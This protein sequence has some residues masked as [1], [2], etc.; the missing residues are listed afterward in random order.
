MKK[1]LSYIALFLICFSLPANASYLSDTL[2]VPKFTGKIY[3][4][5]AAQSDDTKSGRT[6]TAAKKTIGGAES[7]AVA[8]DAITIKAGTYAEDV[9][10]TK[11]A[12]EL[13]GEIGVII[14]GTLYL[15]GDSPRVRGIIITAPANAQ[16]ISLS[17]SYGKIEDT[18]VIGTATTAFN[19]GGSYNMLSHTMAKGYTGTGFNVTGGWNHIM[20]AEANGAGAATRG[21]YLSNTAADGTIV[22]DS[23]SIGNATSSFHI[24]TGV[25]YAQIKN[26]VSGA[27]DGREIDADHVNTWPNFK[28]DSYVYTTTT[29]AGSEVAYTMLTITGGVRL[30]NI[31]GYVE[32]VIP[33]VACT[34]YLQLYSSG[35]TV[36][37]SVAPGVDI[38]AA[39]VGSLIGRTGP[40]TAAMT[41]ANPNTTPAKSENTSFNKPGTEV[42]VVADD[43]NPTYLRLILSAAQASGAIHWHIEWD[44]LT[45]DGIIAAP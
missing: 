18:H 31:Y 1:L 38:D 44:P 27:G 25:S 14:T 32:T 15:Q 43:T 45:D 5:D 13:W 17:G 35:G 36:D 21:F 20:H 7:V 40:S 29:F 9:T 26:C 24:I 16:G 4:V 12:M 8:G 3:Y 37:I 10:I 19:I 11:D 39:V 6:P 41:L 22:E 28:R 33:G 42:D 30:K 2:Y 23:S 34:V